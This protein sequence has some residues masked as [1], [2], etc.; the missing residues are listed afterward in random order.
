MQKETEV[1]HAL[2]GETASGE[3]SN[4]WTVEHGMIV[5]NLYMIQVN[6]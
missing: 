3:T 2:P 6:K 5:A 1:D 4:Q